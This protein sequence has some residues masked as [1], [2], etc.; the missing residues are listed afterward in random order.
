MIVNIDWKTER[1]QTETDREQ[2]ETYREQTGSL[3]TGTQKDR[4]GFL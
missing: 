2:T 3:K 4:L 1:K